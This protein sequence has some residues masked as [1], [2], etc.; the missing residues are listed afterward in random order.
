MAERNLEQMNF[1][2]VGGSTGI[3]YAAAVKVAGSG[4]NVLIVGRGEGAGQKAVEG[5]K[6]AGAGD[7]RFVPADLSRVSGIISAADAIREWRP[8]LHG[9]MHTAMSAFREKKVTQDGFE[10]AFAL[11]YFARAALNRLLAEHLSASGDGRIVH[12][13]GNV[14]G[15]VKANL[16]D[17][18]FEHR[19]WTFYKAVLGTH[20]LGYLHVQELARR[21]FGRNISASVCCVG[22]TKTKVMS[23][24]SMP[25]SMRLMSLFATTPE[26]SARNAIRW[27]TEADLGG[28]NGTIMRNPKKFDPVALKLDPTEAER[29]WWTTS[30]LAEQRGL[31]LPD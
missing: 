15:F 26:K 23:D 14:P 28:V 10:L 1:V 31:Y 9:V 6:K 25:L 27:L 16:D 4:A 2:F 18:Q 30:E 3:G 12:I 24:K 13:A 7:A 17:L 21:W 8:A 5:L 29:L 20:M 22:P 11:Q 19:K